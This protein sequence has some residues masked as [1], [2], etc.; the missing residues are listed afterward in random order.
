MADDIKKFLAEQVM[1]RRKKAKLSQAALAEQTGLSIA[2]I[3]EIERAVTNPTLD[4]LEVLAKV[5]NV[6]VVDLL[7]YEGSLSNA[8]AIKEKITDSLGHFTEKQ[9]QTIL[10]LVRT[11]RK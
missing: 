6:S 11:M 4:T 9:L 3:S 7:D 5:F 2:S 10:S 1:Q 8:N